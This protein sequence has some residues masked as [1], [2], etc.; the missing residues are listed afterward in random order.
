MVD[1]EVEELTCY[2]CDPNGINRK[3]VKVEEGEGVKV[4]HLE[5]GHTS[6]LYFRTLAAHATASASVATSLIINPIPEIELALKNQDYFKAVA[7]LAAMLEYYG[8]LS[9]DE[10]LRAE[11]RN[12]DRDRIY[13][14]FGL[15]DIAIFLY[16]FGMID[17]PCYSAVIALNKLRNDLLHIKDAAEFRRRSGA[18][19]EATIRR[20]MKC[21]DVLM[22]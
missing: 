3:V 19:A 22:R 8:K 6:R 7:Y 15:E 20:A 18:E 1:E 2:Q 17:Q 9:I 10:K 4:R 5:C 21:I 14:G 11:N 12:V 16:G 13:R